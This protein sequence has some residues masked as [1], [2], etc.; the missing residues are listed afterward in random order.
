MFL[1]SLS[2]KIT[3][4][5]EKEKLSQDTISFLKENYGNDLKNRKIHF[6]LEEVKYFLRKKIHKHV[7]EIHEV[8][9]QYLNQQ[10]FI[11]SSQYDTF[12]QALYTPK[13]TEFVLDKF[14]S[15]FKH[16]TQKL[17]KGHLIPIKDSDESQF[18]ETLDQE[19]RQAHV[20]GKLTNI[21]IWPKFSM[22]KPPTQLTDNLD[23]FDV[24]T[25]DNQ[26]ILP[27]FDTNLDPSLKRDLVSPCLNN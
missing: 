22:L 12:N 25:P 3:E 16:K 11:L 1:L 19:I 8:L 24:A 10:R 21:K 2:K 17:L 7:L 18:F 27:V 26:K 9:T 23:F 14:L 6:N 20:Y 5:G 4:L 15:C 13:I